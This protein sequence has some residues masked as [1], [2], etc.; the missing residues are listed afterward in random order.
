MGDIVY[1]YGAAISGQ[2]CFTFFYMRN[3]ET[4]SNAKIQSG[5]CPRQVKAMKKLLIRGVVRHNVRRSLVVYGCQAMVQE[6]S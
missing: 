4:W 5:M 2:D 6:F 3:E 1:I